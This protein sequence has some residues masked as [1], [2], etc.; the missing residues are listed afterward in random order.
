MRL[1]ISVPTEARFQLRGSL[2]LTRVLVTCRSP[3]LPWRISQWVC[4][5]RN[6]DR[7]RDRSVPHLSFPV[8]EE[9]APGF[10]CFPGNLGVTSVSFQGPLIATAFTNGYH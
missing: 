3:A 10:A 1:T 4:R 6:T 8:G 7:A 9:E 2:T 5:G